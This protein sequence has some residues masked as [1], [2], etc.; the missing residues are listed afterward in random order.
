MCQ[1]GKK[2]LIPHLSLPEDNRYN[3]SRGNSVS[4]D[5]C[6]IMWIYLMPPSLHLKIAN[7]HMFCV[8]C[9]YQNKKGKT[10]AHGR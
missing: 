1:E 6:A 2:K 3:T 10:K 7:T 8:M 5:G 9:I 4:H